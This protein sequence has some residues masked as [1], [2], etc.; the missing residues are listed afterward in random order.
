MHPFQKLLTR[1]LS[2]G[3]VRASLVLLLVS[4]LL[5]A[6]LVHPSSVKAA[7]ITIS[8]DASCGMAGGN[9]DPRTNICTFFSPYI[10]AAGDVL[11]TTVDVGFLAGLTNNGIINFGDDVN[12]GTNFQNNGTI[13]ITKRSTNLRISGTNNGT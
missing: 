2:S 9:W 13:N 8:D 6:M 12:I 10:V 4:G 5:L 1:T 3:L 11:Q 7:T